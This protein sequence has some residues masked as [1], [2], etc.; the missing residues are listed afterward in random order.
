MPN[1]RHPAVSIS[2]AKAQSGSGRMNVSV[3]EIQGI[4]IEQK[5]KTVWVVDGIT[6]KKDRR[7]ARHFVLSG[8][9]DGIEWDDCAFVGTMEGN[10][11]MLFHIL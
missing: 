9:K 5:T 4:W 8:T 10:I 3:M 11:L 2:C 1:D 6:A 7:N